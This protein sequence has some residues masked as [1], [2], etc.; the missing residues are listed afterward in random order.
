MRSHLS[1]NRFFVSAALFEKVCT[2]SHVDLQVDSPDDITETDLVQRLQAATG[3]HK[4]N[5]Y[6]F[7]LG[8]I[9]SAEGFLNG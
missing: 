1:P 9:T 6:E 8:V 7:E 3:A 2:G 5:G 4:P